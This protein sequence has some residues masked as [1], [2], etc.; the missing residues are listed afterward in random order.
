[1]AGRTT[2]SEKDLATIDLLHKAGLTL[3]IAKVLAVMAKGEETVSVKIEGLTALRQPEVSIAMRE[4]L[5]RKW[6]KRRSI[7][8]DGKGRPVHGYILTVKFG[9]IVAEL[10]TAQKRKAQEMDKTISRLKRLA[11]GL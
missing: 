9:D 11:K 4:L 3:G 8:K 7:K 6:A 2:L 5:R 10:E 1:M